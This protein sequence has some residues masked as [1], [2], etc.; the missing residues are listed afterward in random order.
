MNDE[1]L[2]IA[3]EIRKALDSAENNETIYLSEQEV[4]KMMNEF[5]LRFGKDN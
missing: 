2:K 5:K 3:D 4:E 1:E